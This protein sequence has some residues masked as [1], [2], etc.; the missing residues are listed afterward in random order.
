MERCLEI[1]ETIRSE[2]V[3]NP[4]GVKLS[5]YLGEIKTQ[6]LPYRYE[7]TD[8]NASNEEGERIKHLNIL[9]RGKVAKIK[10]ER[11]FAVR[12]N[13]MLQFYGFEP[14]RDMNKLAKTYIP[15]NIDKIRVSRTTLGGKRTWT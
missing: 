10:W 7:T 15:E 8:I 4:L 9:T 2:G 11:R 12:F 6:F 1:A 14:H 13:Q 3:M 5:A